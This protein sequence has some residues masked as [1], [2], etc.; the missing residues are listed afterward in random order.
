MY[1]SKYVCMSA[2]VCKYVC[3]HVC[4]Y[5]SICVHAH[6]HVYV[7]LSVYIY[8]H[9]YGCNKTCLHIHISTCVERETYEMLRVLYDLQVWVSRV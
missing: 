9:A 7:Y 5:V 1:V 8:T 2:Y 3:M 6:A 4:M